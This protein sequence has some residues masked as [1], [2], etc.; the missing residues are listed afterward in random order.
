MYWTQF[1]SEFVKVETSKFND[2]FFSFL[3]FVVQ[4]LSLETCFPQVRGCAV[5]KPH[6]KIPDAYFAGFA[7]L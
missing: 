4:R 5:A 7:S 1:Y 2:F 3:T 6:T